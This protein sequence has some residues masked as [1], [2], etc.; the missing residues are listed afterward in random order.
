MMQGPDQGNNLFGLLSMLG[1]TLRDAGAAYGGR[2]SDALPQL[3][4]TRQR[5]KQYQDLQNALAQQPTAPGLPGVDITPNQITGQGG[6]MTV[7]PVAAGGMAGADSLPPQLAQLLPSLPPEVGMQLLLSTL[8]KQNTPIKGQPGDVFFDPTTGQQRFAVPRE[9]SRP[10]TADEVARAGLPAGT[11]A[12]IGPDGKINILDKGYAPKTPQELSDAAALERAKSDAALPNQL[13]L[14]T[15]RGEITAANTLAGIDAR[16]NAANEAAQYDM[17]DPGDKAYIDSI[18]N[19]RVRPPSAGRNPIQRKAAIEAALKV[20]PDYNEGLY[21]QSAKALR[22]FGT[23]KQGDIARSLNVSVAHL[24]TLRDLGRA[25]NNGD[26][27]VINAVKQR[28]A[29]EFGVPAPTNF[30]TAKSI[31]ADEVAKG[32]IG[33]QTAQSDRETLASSLRRSRSFDQIDGAITTFQSLL[34]GQLGG[35]RSQYKRTTRA[36]DFDEAFLS[37][38]TR[39]ALGASEARSQAGAMPAAAVGVPTATGPNG[40]K[41]YLRNGQWAP[42]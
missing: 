38:A 32:V 7:P 37:D 14:A 19:Y 3:L 17:N 13:T 40:Q 42:Q 36:N 31:V 33:G 27:N 23:G 12:Q 9:Q 26:V 18:A 21:D 28:F 11:S 20:N 6:G 30:D 4:A 25:L 34:G 1:A 2:Q 5:A 15:K 22:D 41:L 39:R 8:T 24:E 29:E 16:T 35:L 10:L